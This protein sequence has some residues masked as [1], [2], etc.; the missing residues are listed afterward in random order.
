M[1]SSVSTLATSAIPLIQGWLDQERIDNPLIADVEIATDVELGVAHRWY[2]RMPGEEK[3]FVTV[4][5]TVKERTLHV[6]TY[7]CPAPAENIAEMYEYLLRVN[8]RLHGVA[9]AIGG[10]DALYLVGQLPLDT[11]C[12]AHLDRLLGTMYAVSEECFPT[13]MRIGYASQFRT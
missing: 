1:T 4:W 13:A 10:E 12:P 3:L 6:E 8:Q 5:L 2:V 7:V 11:L 9:F